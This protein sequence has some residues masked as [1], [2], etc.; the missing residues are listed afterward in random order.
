MWPVTEGQGGQ[1]CRVLFVTQRAGSAGVCAASCSALYVE[2]DDLL[3]TADFECVYTCVL[4]LSGWPRLRPIR[5][6][7]VSGQVSLGFYMFKL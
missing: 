5:A 6:K 4:A 7:G 1:K 2:M 3:N